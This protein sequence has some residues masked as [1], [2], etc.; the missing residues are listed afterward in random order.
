MKIL[1]ATTAREAA[2]DHQ[3]LLLRRKRECLQ[4]GAALELSGLDWEPVYVDF[5]GGETRGEAYRTDVNPMGEAPVMVAAISARPI[6]RD[7]ALHHRRDR[8]VRRRDPRRGLRGAA[9]GAVGQSQAR[10]RPA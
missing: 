6:G 9:L 4:G 10:A 3:A 8:Q 5:F 2:N 7:P 1:N